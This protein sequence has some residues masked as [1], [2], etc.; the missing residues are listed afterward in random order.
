MN[1]GSGDSGGRSARVD[2]KREA[3]TRRDLV[4]GAELR[5]CVTDHGE[6]NPFDR[7]SGTQ[8]VARARAKPRVLLVDDDPLVARGIQRLLGPGYDTTVAMSAHEAVAHVIDRTFEVVVSDISMPEVDGLCLLRLIRE[9]DPRAAVVLLTGAPELETAMSA[10]DHGAFQYL[11]KPATLDRLTSVISRALQAREIARLKEDLGSLSAPGGR[12]ATTFERAL[13]GAW[14]AYQPIVR[15]GSHTPYGCEALVRSHEGPLADAAALVGAAEQ[16]GRLP[17]LGRV[18]RQRALSWL[19]SDAQESTLFLNVHAPELDDPLLLSPSSPLSKHAGR[20]V[21]E[22]TDRA[23]L[24]D[25]E[26]V[27]QRT[28]ELRR[29]GYRIAIDDM[30]A[31]YAALT[32]FAA[33]EPDIVKIDMSL[34]RNVDTSSTKQ[35]LVASIASLCKDLQMPLVAEGVETRAEEGV[36]EALGCDLLQG[37]L[38]AQPDGT[39]VHR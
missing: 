14:L 1:L 5:A 36:L 37:Y 4:V 34:V 29:I 38:Y 28:A 3:R 31:G 8:P 2:E 17:A 32:S 9:H 7:P 26:M 25:V 18:V 19:T 10:A 33:I 23:A 6:L 15:A 12:L 20:I 27:R 21:L 16:L 35:K 30:G 22:L 13:D 11:V 39:G 24:H